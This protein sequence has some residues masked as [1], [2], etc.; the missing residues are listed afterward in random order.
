MAGETNAYSGLMHAGAG[1]G[2]ALVQLSVVLPGLLPLIG[3]VGVFCVV[4][5]LPLLAVGLAAALLA[6]PPVAAWLVLK[7]VRARR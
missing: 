1:T 4:L 5:L 2:L 7:R 3:L 6:A